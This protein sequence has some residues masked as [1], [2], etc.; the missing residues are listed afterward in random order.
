MSRESPEE[1][2]SLLE[3]WLIT[4]GQPTLLMVVVGAY[5]LLA[6]FGPQNSG[7]SRRNDISTRRKR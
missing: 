3:R 4:A 7:L 2:M 1:F 6:R 5:S